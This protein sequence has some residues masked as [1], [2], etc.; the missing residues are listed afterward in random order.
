MTPFETFAARKTAEATGARLQPFITE[1]DDAAGALEAIGNEW[2]R[3]ISGGAFY[4]TPSPDPRR[5]ACSLVF[6]QS[7]D[8]NTGAHNPFT[9]GGGETDKHAIY[10]GLSGV[11]DRRDRTL[12]DRPRRR[13]VHRLALR[14]GSGCCAHR[15]SSRCRPGA[16]Y[17]RRRTC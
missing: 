14:R 2:S 12:V 11:E 3:H 9:L 13:R 17:H 8:G 15:Q 6:V 10:E 7:L 1:F 16:G 5:P 4:A